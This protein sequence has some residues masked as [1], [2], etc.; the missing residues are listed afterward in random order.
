[1]NSTTSMTSGQRFCVINC[2]N[3][4]KWSP[5][6]FSDMFIKSFSKDGEE[7]VDCEIAKGQSLPNDILQFQGIVITG[8]RFNCRDRDSLPWFDSVC[9]IIRYANENGTPRIFGGCFGCQIIAFAL[10]GEVDYNPDRKF[11]LKAEAVQLKPEFLSI[12]SIDPEIWDGWKSHGAKILVSHGDCVR[13]LPENSVHL[14]TSASCVNEVFVCGLK[15]NILGCQ[16]HPEFDFDYAIKD[17]I[18]P[19]VVEIRKKLSPEEIDES[20]K[21]FEDYD[22][23]DAKALM[24]VISQFLHTRGDS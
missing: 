20:R 19:S 1:M 2:E 10:G 5:Y 11:A 24:E 18:W 9:N 22:G 3:G 16:S 15:Q 23:K 12:V 21:T 13:L 8:S 4:E 6:T 7:W 17:R 14:G